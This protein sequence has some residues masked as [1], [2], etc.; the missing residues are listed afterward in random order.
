[1]KVEAWSSMTGKWEPAT[2]QSIDGNRYFVH[3]LDP[4][5]ANAY[6]GATP[7]QVRAPGAGAAPANAP[8]LGGTATAV[9]AG[10]PAPAAQ[11][12][13]AG[14][15]APATGG[16]KRPEGSAEY[17]KTPDGQTHLRAI[18][19]PGD[20]PPLGH[21]K[22][23]AG[24]QSVLTGRTNNG[25]GTVTERHEWAG[26]ESAGSLTINADGTWVDVSP[27]GTRTQGRWKD[28]GQNRAEL[29]GYDGE[30][31]T[32]STWKGELYMVNAVGQY[33]YGRRH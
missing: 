5:I 7:S 21:W 15:P 28:M 19:G 10:K 9:P 31:W 12:A 13:P 11:P 25:E 29:I 23:S 1:D 20:E 14:K 27:S 30:T 26:P 16:T 17:V 3:A 18:I 32:A 2:I 24:G 33:E 4:N 22:L 6:W 8:A